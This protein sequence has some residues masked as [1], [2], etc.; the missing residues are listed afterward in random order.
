[1]A[2]KIV[3]TKNVPDFDN[4]A[5]FDGKTLA[6]SK[7]SDDEFTLKD[8]DGTSMVFEG[9]DF[10]KTK[11]VVTGGTIESAEFYNNKG[12]RIYTFDDLNAD[13]AEL[14]KAFTLKDDPLRILHGLMEGDDEVTGSKRKDSMW[15]FAGNDTLDGKAGDDWLYGHRGDDMLTGGAGADHFVFQTGYDHDTVTDFDL[16]GTDQDFIYL[17]YYLYKSIVYTQDGDDLTLT[18]STGD[19]LT[20]IDVDRADL[21]EKHFDFY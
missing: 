8:K 16:S 18:L 5:Q 1:M 6:I 13:A 2:T 14:F 19:S 21:K 17:D 4:F 15:G 3:Y 10:E 12:Q 7:L 11:S 9:S 20:L